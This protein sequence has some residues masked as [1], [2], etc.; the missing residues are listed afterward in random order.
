[1][2]NR[3]EFLQAAGSAGVAAGVLAGG[4]ALA[5]AADEPAQGKLTQPVP[6]AVFQRQGYDP[7]HATIHEPGGPKLGFADVPLAGEFGDVKYDAWQFRVVP[8]KDAFGV[9]TD[10][11]R[12][13]PKIQDSK[14]SAI[15]K[16]PAGGWYR[17]EVR[18]ER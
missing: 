10:W 12:L 7:L 9:G 16:I 5:A 14:L 2:V 11:A 17:L 18:A 8:L 15:A 13:E 1:M 4:N 3:R 6:Y